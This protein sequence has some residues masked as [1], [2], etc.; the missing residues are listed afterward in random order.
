MTERDRGD[1]G[2][3]TAVL[4]FSLPVGDEAARRVAMLE[5]MYALQLSLC[6]CRW[7]S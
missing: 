3:G 1:G 7:M 4:L 6:P 2:W 5:T